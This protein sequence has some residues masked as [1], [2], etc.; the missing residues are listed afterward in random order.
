MYFILWIEIHWIL[1]VNALRAYLIKIKDPITVQVIILEK[2]LCL[3]SK[4]IKRMVQDK[5]SFTW[6]LN[7]VSDLILSHL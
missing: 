4:A 3:L 6:L 2:S 5:Y 1:K 7:E